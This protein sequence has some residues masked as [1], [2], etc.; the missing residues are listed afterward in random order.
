MDDCA[1]PYNKKLMYKHMTQ[2]PFT[3]DTLFSLFD[4][5]RCTTMSDD[6]VNALLTFVNRC[7]SEAIPKISRP[8]RISIRDGVRFD[9]DTITTESNSWLVYGVHDFVHDRLQRLQQIADALPFIDRAI[10]RKYALK[11]RLAARVDALAA[12]VHHPDSAYASIVHKRSFTE[13]FQ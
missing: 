4:L 7:P 9:T 6:D 2:R 1:I 11:N 12:K 5:E 8:L 13:A 3:V 10:R